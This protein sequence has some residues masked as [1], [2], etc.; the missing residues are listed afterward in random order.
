MS[1][2]RRKIASCARDFYAQKI[3]ID[4]L[5]VEAAVRDED[6]LIDELIDLI[7][8]EPAVGRIFG[9]SKREHDAHIQKIYEIIEKFER[10]H[11]E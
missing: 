8:H 7:V 11:N 4:E 10:Q 5:L 3:T 6:D 1:E 9:V 2:L